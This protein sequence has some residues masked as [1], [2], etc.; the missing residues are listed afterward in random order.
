MGIRVLESKAQIKT[1]PLLKNKP[2]MMHTEESVILT[3]FIDIDIDLV[4]HELGDSELSMFSF[5]ICLS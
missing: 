3:L 1:E 5:R 4:D 2:Q